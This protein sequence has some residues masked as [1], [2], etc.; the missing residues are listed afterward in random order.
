MLETTTG[1][2]QA[3]R[4]PGL[5]DCLTAQPIDPLLGIIGA[6][7]ADPRPAK[8][9]V[10]VGVYKDEHGATPVFAAVKEAEAR[11]LA[12][13]STKA[14]L[15]PEGDIGFFELLRPLVL[16]AGLD[17]GRVSGLQTPGGTGALRLAA[18]LIAAANPDAR[19]LV[20]VPTWP[21][22]LPIL[23]AAALKVDPY[24]YFDVPTQTITFAA[25]ADALERGR[26]G[27]VVLLHGCCHNPV[28]ADLDQA[29]WQ[30]VAA[31]V[32]RRGLVPLVDLAYQGL[33]AGMEQ[34]ARGARTVLAAAD[35]GLLAYSCDKNFGLYRERTG[36]LFALSRSREAAAVTQSNLLSL[37]RA[38]WSM[39]P[40]HGAAVVRVILEDPELTASWS[41]ELDGMRRRIV[42]VRDRLAGLHP[43]L[44]PLA[45][46]FGMF[47]TL[48]LTPAE[49]DRLR[50]ERGVYMAASGRISVAGLTSKTI[51]PFAAA[52][53]EVRPQGG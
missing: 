43:M 18:E 48:A 49:V 22:H 8:I 5:L 44:A 13:Q 42:G 53:A 45:H 51:A 34:D 9:D 17:N 6:F 38:A 4:S 25:M 37:A 39:P 21:N 36:A 52:L 23:A 35:E 40:D 32:A 20:G 1:A 2:E 11:L 30:A 50:I 28:G 46:H 27:D 14:Y 12:G 47:S 26:P 10:G 31:I 3:A 29:Q 33:G 41:A 16:G 15:G 24:P 7:R 19:V